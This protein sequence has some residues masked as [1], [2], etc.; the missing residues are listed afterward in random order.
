VELTYFQK[1]Y[2]AVLPGPG[3]TISLF[4]T[5]GTLLARYPDVARTLGQRFYAAEIFSRLA[6]ND[7]HVLRRQVSAVDGQDRLIALHRLSRLPMALTTTLTLDAA[8]SDWRHLAALLLGAALVLM[9]MLGALS[10]LLWRQF[11]QQRVLAEARAA[12]IQ[13]DRKILAAAAE[14][15]LL[16]ASMPAVLTRLGRG[17]DGAWATLYTAPSIEA[18]LGFP[19][20]VAIRPGWLQDQLSIAD[21]GLLRGQLNQALAKGNGLVEVG[22]RHADGS[23]RRFSGAMRAIPAPANTEEVIIVWTDVTRERALADQLA[24]AAKLASLG[25]V[26]TGMAH[27]LNQPLSTISMAAENLGRAMARLPEVTPRMRQKVSLITD[28]A[29]RA[30]GIIDHM[31]VFGRVSSDPPEP[32]QLEPLLH[33]IPDLTSARLRSSPVRLELAVPEDLPAFM[34]RTGPLEQVM[35]TLLAN[36]CDAYDAMGQASPKAER[37]VRITATPAEGEICI[38]VS[39]HAGGIPDDIK[40]RI[41]EPFFTTK[42]VGQGTGLGLSISYGLVT[43]MGGTITAENQDGGA[44]FTIRFAAAPP[45]KSLIR[46]AA[47]A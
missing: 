15:D 20:A 42:P 43:E 23:A 18:V 14:L 26:A 5:D 25:E 39:D 28:Q 45:E 31:R 24:Q 35:V 30:A 1:L 8:L 3:S 36:A 9:A 27:E 12:Q 6:E 33:A 29:H 38:T 32:L 22:F 7:G 16:N 46:H 13:A 17:P 21:H 19:R 4:R 44:C 40:A 47:P 37:I 41:F 34:G 2:A 11:Q 10:A